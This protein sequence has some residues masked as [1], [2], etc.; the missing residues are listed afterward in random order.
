MKRFRFEKDPAEYLVLGPMAGVTDRPF[1][2]LC[3]EMGAVLCG[4][5]MVSANAI[6][7][8]NRKT[9]ELLAIDPGEH[10][11]SLQLFGPDPETMAIAALYVAKFPYDVL[12]I[13]M[14]CPMPKIVNNGEGSAL[15]KDPD[16]CGRIVEACV[17]AQD[18]P[19]TVKIRAGYSRD[20]VNAPEVAKA[21][22]AAGAAAIA[23]HGRTREQL[24]EGRADWGVIADVVRTVSVPVL[25]NGDVHSR[26]D[27]ERMKEETGCDYVMIARGARGNPW[28][29]RGDGRKPD[30]DTVC[31]MILRHA[32]M[33]VEE[34]GEHLGI[35]QMRKHLAWYTT[36]FQNAAKLRA[37]GNIVTS[38][39]ELQELTE[40]W[41]T[42]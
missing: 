35:L 25:G 14:G 4:M 5:E 19:V 10:P 3:H 27:A 11:V 21:C 9:E 34:K 28:I 13:N 12:D 22:E 20:A 30:K 29:F 8:G 6:K 42:Q 33:Q 26:A 40:T 1:R 38:F 16:L 39:A 31:D 7:Y 24:Y 17:R 36:G 15:M 18:R 2:L 32:K 37:A 23:V 41:R